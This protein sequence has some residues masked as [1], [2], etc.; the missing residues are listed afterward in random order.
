MSLQFSE[1]K[2]CCLFTF[3]ATCSY[4]LLITPP[5]SV[6]TKTLSNP[7]RSAPHHFD[8]L[9]LT[10]FVGGL[11]HC[12]IY[13]PFFHGSVCGSV[14]GCFLRTK[15]NSV[16]WEKKKAWRT[17][18]TKTCTIQHGDVALVYWLW[19]EW[20]FCERTR[21][22]VSENIQTCQWFVLSPFPVVFSLLAVI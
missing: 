7:P 5:H 19:V 22:R 10:H 17:K 11:A 18:R 21:G 12:F 15:D 4:L 16:V 6:V 13:F 9:T 2:P 1:W 14:V 3:P 8:R 20:V